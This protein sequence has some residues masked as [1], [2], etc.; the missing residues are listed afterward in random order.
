[1]KHLI[2]L[3][4]S[5]CGL[6]NLSAQQTTTLK[7][8]STQRPVSL[9][10][11]N[12]NSL[13]KPTWENRSF[14]DSV[15]SLGMRIIRYPGG[16]E[17]QYFDWQTGRIVPIDL[18]LN[19]A[20]SNF[21]YLATARAVPHKLEDFKVILEKTSAKPLFCLNAITSTLSQQLDMLR[22]AR[23]LGIAVDYI[24]LANELFFEDADFVKKYPTAADY[25][26]DMR[27]WIDSIRKE[28]PG[29]KIAILGA[30][31]DVLTP[32]LQPTPRRISTWNDALFEANLQADAI[33]FHHYFLPA[34][35]RQMPQA[36]ELLEGAFRTWQRYKAYNIGQRT[37]RDGNLAYRIQF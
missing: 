22:R 25:A 5:V 32:S 17:S 28:F 36:S 6:L 16:T 29:A 30:T 34:T 13:T 9:V 37:Q 15:H 10:G 27:I 24:E 1:M 26:A 18:W 35:S 19:G 4:L 21:Q 7:I 20:L 31:E 8:A 33:T 12:L 3:Y 2:F 23:Q 14:S 11:F